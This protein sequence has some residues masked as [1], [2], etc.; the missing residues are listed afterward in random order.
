MARRQIKR[1]TASELAKLPPG[2]HFDGGDGLA[3]RVQQSGSRSWIQRVSIK[4]G[5]RVDLGLGGYPAVK[6]AEARETAAENRRL[7][8]RGTD[9]RGSQVPT[10]AECANGWIASRDWSAKDTCISRMR[11]FV[12][13]VMGS[14]RVDRIDAGHV[15]RVVDRATA[16]SQKKM[17]VMEIG[18]ILDWAMARG[19]RSAVNP[20]PSIKRT[21][22][23][24]KPER[25]KSMPAE[26]VRDALNVM[27][28][29]N[30]PYVVKA[31]YRFVALTCVRLREASECRH[32]EFDDDEWTDPAERMGKTKRPFVVPVPRQAMDVVGRA[33]EEVW[34]DGDEW[35]G[36][37]YVFTATKNGK[38]PVPTTIRRWKHVA[39]IEADIH[40]FRSSFL[41]WAADKGIDDSLADKCLSHTVDTPVRQAY[42]R[43]DLLN[44]RREVLQAWADYITT[45]PKRPVL[46]RSD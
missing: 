10:F 29:S 39:G 6:L 36:R 44:R 30:A 26:E 33:C 11:R 42:L 15:R 46:Y 22:R 13:P 24:P 12:A 17:S 19:F 23:Q 45:E 31:I 40:G 41:T 27:D 14:V 5:A 37:G 21:I 28:K 16:P 1:L 35:D 3:L 18:M 2:W 7:A 32:E 38:P 20:C 34:E 43:T 4:D 8:R 25:R 9:P